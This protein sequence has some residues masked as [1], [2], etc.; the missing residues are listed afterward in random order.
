MPVLSVC[1]EGVTTP[2]A[3]N[4]YIIGN[5]IVALDTDVVVAA[6]RTQAY[7][8]ERAGRADLEEFDRIL[9]KAGTEPPRPGDEPPELP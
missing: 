6:L 3:A 4:R 5:M 7:F 1:T 2:I 8:R 9:A